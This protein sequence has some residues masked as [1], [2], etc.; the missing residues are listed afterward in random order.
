[1]KAYNPYLY[2]KLFARY[3]PVKG[4]K[5]SLIFDKGKFSIIFIDSIIFDFIQDSKKYSLIEL[6][7][8]YL[9]SEI[10]TQ[11]AIDEL[12]KNKMGF[13]CTKQESKLFPEI[14][15]YWDFPSIIS[16]AIIDYN[17]NSKYS[18]KTIIEQ[19]IKLKC[20][21]VQFRFFDSINLIMIDDICI[22]IDN[23]IITRIEF[24]I[25]YDNFDEADIIKLADK[26]NRIDQIIIHSAP[27][28]KIIKE[29]VN[30]KFNLIYTT[31]S[32]INCDNC[33]I[34]E[35]SYFQIH[36]D[37]LFESILHNSCLNRKI[38]ID[39]NGEI[40]NCP[41]MSKSYGNIKNT[42][43]AEAIEK[44]GFKD[45]WLVNKDRIEVCKD[46]E[47]R[48]FCIDCRAYL[49]DPNNIF[50]QPVKCSYNPYIS[51]WEGENDY[52]PINS[53]IMNN[54]SLL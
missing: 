41:S 22:H 35:P 44:P 5:R 40:K 53:N 4:Y 14:N 39:I 30:D 34:I 2:F 1:M 36:P 51:K 33:G 8:K 25:K 7:K 21:S 42:T 50:S 45:T 20:R 10:D 11:E 3:I 26:Y 49:K 43:I 9:K 37:I 54:I 17:S 32:I 38:G 13:L 46:C 52:I 29:L 19:L 27:Y 23:S 28:D 6:Q 12:V 31:Q 16:N 15:T 18:F 48:Y 24:I 47:F